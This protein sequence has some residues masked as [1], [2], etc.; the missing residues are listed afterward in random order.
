MSLVNF[1]KLL[2]RP[3]GRLPSPGPR[4]ASSAYR[5][6]RADLHVRLIEPNP[7][8]IPGPPGFPNCTGPEKDHSERDTCVSLKNCFPT[9][10]QERFSCLSRHWMYK[11]VTQMKM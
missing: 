3:K 10:F 4:D 9:V 8:P 5:A 6:S 11:R 7:V 1:V 2:Y